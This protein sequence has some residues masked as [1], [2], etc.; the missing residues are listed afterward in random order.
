MKNRIQWIDSLKGF[1][2]LLVVMGHMNYASYPSKTMLF[3]VIYSFHMA[4]FIFLS[5]F[6]ISELSLQKLYRKIR[7]YMFPFFLWGTLFSLLKTGNS[8]YWLF[9]QNKYYFWYLLVLF[10]CV[11]IVYFIQFISHHIRLDYKTL[12][13]FI[14][15][16]QVAVLFLIDRIIP[17][18]I[19]DVFCFRA[20]CVNFPFFLLGHI[21][22]TNERIFSFIC[23]NSIYTWA[24]ILYI[25][26]LYLT[27]KSGNPLFRVMTALC[28]IIVL[29][30]FFKDRDLG[31]I[32]KNLATIG[33]HSLNVYLFHGFFLSMFNLELLSSWVG[34]TSN[35]AIELIILFLIS[36]FV[37]VLAIW[38]G[39]LVQ[40]SSIL[41][42]YLYG[43]Q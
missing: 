41:S 30:Q 7:A 40:H 6:V 20:L 10:Y 12:I 2:I 33:F 24:L 42:K 28:A 13:F 37:A 39:L 23:R 11:F 17:Q 43:K 22:R 27:T 5:G 8:V 32:G 3:N 9:L 38:A 35:Y 34:R 18:T 31:F 21:C 25:P 1:L 14:G 4:V 16:G 36:L 29:V 26:L 19:N 15:G